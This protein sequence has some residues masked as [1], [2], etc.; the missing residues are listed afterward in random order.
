MV[1]RIGGHG[2]AALAVLELEAVQQELEELRPAFFLILFSQD[3]RVLALA[4][5]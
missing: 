1:L 2:V 4:L 3:V 5:G